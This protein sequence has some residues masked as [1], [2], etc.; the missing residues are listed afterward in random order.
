[1]DRADPLYIRSLE[2]A[3]RI[4]S[5]FDVDRPSLSLAQVGAAAR[6]DR[7]AAQRFT[8]TLERLGYLR[9]DPETRRFELTTRTLDLGY[10]FIRSHPL[11]QQALPYLQHL[12]R[13]TEEAVSLSVLDGTEI[14]YV[15]RFMSRQMLATNVII[16]TRLPAYC[17]SPGRAILSRLDAV[18]RR[19]I[20]QASRLHR[21]TPSTTTNPEALEAIVARAAECGYAHAY[22]EIF[23][24]DISFA[25][26]VVGAAGRPAGA[27]SI[28]VTSLHYCASEAEGR[29]APLVVGTARSISGGPWT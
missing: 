28:S 15:S 20:L 5:V 14:V 11:V 27:V 13:E 19:A 17:S 9:K 10:H 29:F 8:H 24:G 21:Y 4:L 23:P 2:K 22:D 18:E 25:A 1:M 16:G 6:L 3:F 12:S 7:S 26:P